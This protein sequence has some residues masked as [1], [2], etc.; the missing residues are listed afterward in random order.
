MIIIIAND[1]DP[2]LPKELAIRNLLLILS[3]PG[4]IVFRIFTSVDVTV[5]QYGK[6]LYISFMI[7]H[8]NI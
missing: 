8:E 5:Y 2:S 6:M 1:E 4:R 3:T 7:W